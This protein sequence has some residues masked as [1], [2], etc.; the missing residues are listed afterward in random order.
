MGD[1][2]TRGRVVAIAL[3]DPRIPSRDAHPA[4][5]SARQIAAAAALGYSGD[6]TPVDAWDVVRSGLAR[7]VDVRTAEERRFVG[8]VPGSLHVPWATGVA[9]TRNPRFIRELEDQVRRDEV[10]LLICRCGPR[11]VAAAIAA[12]QARFQHAYNVSEGFEGDLDA[13]GHRGA[14]GGWRFHGLPWQQD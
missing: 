9:M 12:T 14:V 2:F 7:L 11:S 13:D 1:S 6:L 5:A 8:H 4:L 3:N 10:V